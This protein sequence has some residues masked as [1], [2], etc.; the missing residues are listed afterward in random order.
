MNPPL[1]NALLVVF[2]ATLQATD[3]NP[4]AK[5]SRNTPATRPLL[6]ALLLEAL[7][8]E[9]A[10]RPAAACGNPT[11]RDTRAIPSSLAPYLWESHR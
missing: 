9:Q 3:L 4:G 5:A 11:D 2:L 8:Q 10:L 1:M 7:L 6:Q